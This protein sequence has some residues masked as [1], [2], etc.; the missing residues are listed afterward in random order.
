[1]TPS[2]KSFLGVKRAYGVLFS[3]IISVIETLG[4][5]K[6]LEI[7]KEVVQRRGREDGLE[8]KRRLGVVND[9]IFDG[10]AVYSAFIQ[11]SGMNF[12][13]IEETDE[14]IVLRIGKCPVFEASH[15]AILDCQYFGE[16]MCRLI[17]LPLASAVVS[18]IHP[19]L[20]VDLV[21]YR[22]FHD[23]Y[24]IEDISLKEK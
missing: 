13:V 18:V 8:L 11:D 10:L 14:K 23:G 9:S 1:M 17:Y 5:D 20:S 22:T 15:E 12:D 24:C 4:S 2:K 16:R 3:Y 6:A 21:R 7:L 19:N